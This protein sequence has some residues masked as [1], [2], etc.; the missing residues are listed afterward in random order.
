MNVLPDILFRNNED[1]P[2]WWIT[3]QAILT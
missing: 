2:V 1:F 3:F